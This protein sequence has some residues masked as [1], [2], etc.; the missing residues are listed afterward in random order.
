MEVILRAIRT[1]E[2]LIQKK[3]NDILDVLE[4]D[5]FDEDIQEATDFGSCY[6]FLWVLT[7][8]SQHSMK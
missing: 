2:S 6:I 4:E 3:D 5:R 7:K 8:W 1:K